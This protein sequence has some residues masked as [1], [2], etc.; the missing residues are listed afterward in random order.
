M[1]FESRY[2]AV[3][4]NVYRVAAIILTACI[5]L[6]DVLSPLEG[7]VAVLY[8]LAIFLVAHS[9]RRW[10]IVTTVVICLVLTA[11]AYVI[12]HGLPLRDAPAL[13]ALVSMAA[14]AIALTLALRNQAATQTLGAQAQL[15]DLSHD[16]I[17]VTDMDGVIL[18]WNR[19]ATDTYGWSAAEAIGKR[20]DDLLK[21]IFPLDRAHAQ[22]TLLET[23]RWDGAMEH[24]ARD[25]KTFALESRWALA[26]GPDNAI[27]G[28]ME[29]H[30]DVSDRKAAHAALVQSERRFRRMFDATRMG[31]VQE[32]WSDVRAALKDLGARELASEFVQRARSLVHIEGVNPALLR[33]VGADTDSGR[34]AHRTADDILAETDRSFAGALAAFARGDAFFEGETNIV[35]TDG[36]LV[37][38][39]F[40]ITFP[41]SPDD[42]DSVLVF[43][44]DITDI[45]HAQDALEQAHAELAH[46]ARVATLGELTASIAHEVNQP[47]MA[48]VTNGEAGLRW[49]RRDRPELGE[50]ETSLGRVVAEGR[51]AGEIVK[52]IRAFLQKAPNQ[53][54]E[55]DVAAI[56]EDATLL[57]DRE[58]ARSGAQ[59]TADI[60]P[61]LPMVLGDR[62]QLQQVMVNL[63]VN[64][65][66][67]MAGQDGEQRI[68]ITARPYEGGMIEIAVRDSG[69][70]IAPEHLASL[71][72]PFYTTKAEGMGMGLPICRTTVEAHG[73]TLA[74]NGNPGRG[75]EFVVKLPASALGT[76]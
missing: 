52:R 11:L 28:I 67:A 5:F 57:L 21:T 2:R 51:R 6:F 31:V 61:G 38:V 18:F 23:G 53:R 56:I 32:D 8:V 63:L 65:S 39:L 74:V 36:R 69:P 48:I 9:G 15:I 20:A 43:M 7:A 41:T 55:L 35:A 1:P 25:G 40:T 70:G 24:T 33:I 60:S 13:R 30:T 26:R 17:F 19:A 10:E 29:T 73:G 71:F 64:A 44:I 68:H 46:A 14:L 54:V 37:P 45:R 3:N 72:E 66:Q 75:A 59:V 62:V 58:L 4:P 47:L 49:L 27:L 76:T 12:S 34:A 16:M 50:V 22:R 42:A